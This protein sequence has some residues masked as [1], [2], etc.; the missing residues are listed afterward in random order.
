[1]AGWG[2]TDDSDAQNA[3]SYIAGLRAGAATGLPTPGYRQMFSDSLGH[4]GWTL[5]SLVQRSGGDAE[6]TRLRGEIT[7][8][9]TGLRRDIT[10]GRMDP[11]NLT[12]D[13]TNLEEKVNQMLRI[14]N[15]AGG[16]YRRKTRKGRGK[17][18]RKT[19]RH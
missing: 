6:V 8:I 17:T 14:R 19:R 5:D 7:P 13:V 4:L 16:R 3:R 12:E 10:A 1:M 9:L 2:S 18:S 11:T 15:L